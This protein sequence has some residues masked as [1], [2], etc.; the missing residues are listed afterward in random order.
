MKKADLCIRPGIPSRIC[1]DWGDCGP[2][3]VEHS[4]KVCMWIHMYYI[5]HLV[6]IIHYIIE[7]NMNW[8]GLENCE[9]SK[10]STETRKISIS[11]TQK[12]KMKYNQ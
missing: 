4:R 2:N 7:P 10:V 8:G 1:C 11:S 6:D 5:F 9:R 3:K 12:F